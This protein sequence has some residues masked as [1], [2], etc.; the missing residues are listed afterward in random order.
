M[1]IEYD[2]YI[3]GEPFLNS[4]ES[5]YKPDIGTQILFYD[6]SISGAHLEFSA[7]VKS[8]QYSIYQ[9]KLT[10]VCEI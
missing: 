10:V 9:D 5:S 1:D 8:Y 3:K 7:I 4:V 6:E 2:F